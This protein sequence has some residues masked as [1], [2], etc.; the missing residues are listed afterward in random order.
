MPYDH[1]ADE[2][3]GFDDGVKVPGHG[4][5]VVSGVRFVALSVAPL[6]QGDYSKAV[7]EDIGH[8]V[9][10]AGVGGEP[11]DQHDRLAGGAPGPIVHPQPVCGHR[12][13][14]GRSLTCHLEQ[15]PR[16]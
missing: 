10:E 16:V 2:A 6:V 5:E 1:R 12:L 11:V 15:R 7:G 13:V 14:S 8:Q 4:G 3:Q 9:P